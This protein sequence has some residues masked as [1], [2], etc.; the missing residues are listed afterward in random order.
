MGGREGLLRKAEMGLSCPSGY[1]GDQEETGPVESA[2]VLQAV[3][4]PRL[5]VGNVTCAG[6]HREGILEVVMSGKPWSL[7]EE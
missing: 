4:G 3:E 7:A 2:Q 1:Q 5:G 6:E